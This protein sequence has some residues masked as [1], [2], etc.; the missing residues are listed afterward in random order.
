MAAP[1][2][3]RDQRE[4]GSRQVAQGPNSRGYRHRNNA[5][6]FRVQSQ[7]LPARL[8]AMC[9]RF[10]ARLTWQQLHDLYWL[11]APVPEPRQ[12]EFGLKPATTSRQ[13]TSTT[14]WT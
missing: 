10:T 2:A 13:P 6:T 3:D 8:R 4:F 11:M 7:R 14:R 12:H 5:R 1:L 9:G